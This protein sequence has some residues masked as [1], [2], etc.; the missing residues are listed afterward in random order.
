LAAASKITGVIRSFVVDTTA[1]LVLPA[2]PQRI[3]IVFSGPTSGRITLS[4]QQDV[5]DLVG[6]VLY[7]TT[8]PFVL[9]ADRFGSLL[10]REWYAIASAG[11]PVLGLIESQ[12]V[13]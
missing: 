5:T 10:T 3:G 7:P 12:W 13:V 11:N 1:R 6:L 2:D 8:V 4:N 9:T